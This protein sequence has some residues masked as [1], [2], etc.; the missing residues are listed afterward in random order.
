MKKL[1]KEVENEGFMALL[2]QRVTIF[3]CRYIY[4]G[5]LTGVN[6][7]CILLSDCGIVY[8]TGALDKKDWGDYQ[9]LPKDFYIQKSAIESF[10]LL[11]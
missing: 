8:E 6:D 5:E 11:K 1:I 7:D 4:T 3:C 2:G 9:K 10:G